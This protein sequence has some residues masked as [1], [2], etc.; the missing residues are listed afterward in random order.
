M[1][2]TT[3]PSAQAIWQRSSDECAALDR[4][5]EAGG[6]TPRGMR[7]RRTTTQLLVSAFRSFRKNP[8]AVNWIRLERRMARYQGFI[9]ATG[10]IDKV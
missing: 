3:R 2:N 7:S 4:S 8:S 5:H 6:N 9:Q 10:G 1:N